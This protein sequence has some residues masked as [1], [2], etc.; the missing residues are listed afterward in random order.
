MT[1]SNRPF[2]DVHALL[3]E[4]TSAQDQTSQRIDARQPVSITLLIQPL[5][6]DFQPIGDPF[7]ALSRDLSMNGVGFLNLETVNYE[8]VRI[9]MVDF[10]ATLVAR[11]RH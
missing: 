8:F 1:Q 11:V 10:N 7:R 5:D 4:L 6:L 3:H 9:S 2:K